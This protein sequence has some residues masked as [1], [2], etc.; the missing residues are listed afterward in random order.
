MIPVTKD[1]RWECQH[2]GRCCVELTPPTSKFGCEDYDNVLNR[3]QIHDKKPFS[4]RIYPFSPDL[5]EIDEEC[6]GMGH[7]LVVKENKLLNKELKNLAAI[8]RRKTKRI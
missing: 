5:K 6:P 7:G 2:C 4:C 3:C 1:T 8:F